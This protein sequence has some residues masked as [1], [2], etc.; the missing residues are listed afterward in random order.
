MTLTLTRTDFTPDGIF[1]ELVDDKGKLSLVTLEHSYDNETKLPDGTYTCLKGIHKL[2]DN[3]P[4]EAYEVMNV[5]GHTGILLHVGNYN[6]DSNGCILLGMERDGI[7]IKHSMIAFSKFM[8]LLEKE[9]SFTLI[10]KGK[11]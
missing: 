1:G 9:E 8:G 5:P 4:F 2:H 7:M 11:V 10:V 3:V 6:K